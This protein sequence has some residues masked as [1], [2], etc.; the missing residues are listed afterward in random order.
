MIFFVAS[1]IYEMKLYQ[2]LF[3]QFALFA[4]LRSQG[5]ECF[6]S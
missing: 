5:T 1:E 6:Q 3:S 4:L 2:I